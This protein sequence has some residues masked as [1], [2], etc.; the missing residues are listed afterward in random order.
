MCLC[1]ARARLSRGSYM[2]RLYRNVFGIESRATRDTEHTARTKAHPHINLPAL[3]TP[4]P[5]P[6][7]VSITPPRQAA[8][9]AS[10]DSCQSSAGPS[11]QSPPPHRSRSRRAPP[12]PPQAARPRPRPPHPPAPRAKGFTGCSMIH[13]MHAFQWQMRA[14]STRTRTSPRSCGLQGM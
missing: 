11:P 2:M 13:Q 8:Q 9:A 4:S 3:P 12:A 6:Y 14:M 1:A 10:A 7:S 5:L